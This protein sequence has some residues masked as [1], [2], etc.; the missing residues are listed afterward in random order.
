M[1]CSTCNWYAYWISNNFSNYN[2]KF[3][4][5]YNRILFVTKWL[6][7]SISTCIS[8]LAIYHNTTSFKTYQFHSNL[9]LFYTCFHLW[10]QITLF[11]EN[12][13]TV[14]CFSTI[15]SLLNAR[16]LYPR[17]NRK[18]HP[19]LILISHHYF[20]RVGNNKKCW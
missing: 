20:L 11:F 2:W 1:G 18:K 19:S 15:N 7:K 5:M 3:Y 10:E 14:L 17:K 13:C 9:C 16:I 12:W 6:T 8:F 4:N